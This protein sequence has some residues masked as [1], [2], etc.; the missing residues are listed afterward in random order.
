MTKAF[1]VTATAWV[2][3]I[4]TALALSRRP[5]KAQDSPSHFV[6][7][8]GKELLPETSTA[9]TP[10]ADETTIY[11]ETDKWNGDVT[12]RVRQCYAF[13][14]DDAPVWIDRPLNLAHDAMIPSS[15]LPPSPPAGWAGSPESVLVSQ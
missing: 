15:S 13:S 3:I 14:S 1:L 4:S 6:F 5:V 9:C 10:G 2:L 7:V 8:G 11:P 12:L